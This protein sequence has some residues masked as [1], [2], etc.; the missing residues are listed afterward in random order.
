MDRPLPQVS[1]EEVLDE[2]GKDKYWIAF[3][4]RPC[5]PPPSAQVAA[6]RID[7]LRDQV[8]E[9]EDFNSEQKTQLLE[10]IDQ[11]EVWYQKSPFCR[12]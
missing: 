8:R 4:V 5:C 7:E 1:F 6:N 10:L 12:G 11:R 2:L 9:R 3:F